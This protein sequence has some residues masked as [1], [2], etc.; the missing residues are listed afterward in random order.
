[1]LVYEM[2]WYLQLIRCFL[3]SLTNSN[4]TPAQVRYVYE[5]P[6]IPFPPVDFARPHSKG[7]SHIYDPLC[8]PSAGGTADH[9]R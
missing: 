5:L 7:H 4:L 9:P 2:G 1:M 6:R 8:T 3:M